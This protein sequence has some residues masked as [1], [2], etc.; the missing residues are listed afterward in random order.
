MNYRAN[1]QRWTVG[2]LAVT[3]LILTAGAIPGLAQ[4]AK[5]NIVALAAR[6][7]K[8]PSSSA[9]CFACNYR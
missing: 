9:N 6:K 5:P 2:A 4:D 3:G 8:L 1:V 7:A